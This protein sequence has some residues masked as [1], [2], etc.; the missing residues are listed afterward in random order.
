MTTTSPPPSATAERPTTPALQADGVTKRFAGVTAL[1][2]VS[3]SVQP[4][5]IHALVGENGAGKS[6]LI[7][8]LTG[9]H[10]PDEGRLLHQGVETSFGRAADAQDAGIST[11]YQEVN[12]VPLLSVA[13][14]VF[15]GR[16]PRTRLGLVDVRRME[17]EAAEITRD[18]GVDVDVTGDL[19]RLGLG[20]Q[21]MIALARAV[22]VDARVVI[23]DE[24]TSSLERREVDTLFTVARRLRD[25][26]VG[27][28]FVSHRLDELWQLCDAVTILR[29][30]RV[31][32]TGEMAPLT[33]RELISHMLGRD[34][35]D[36]A[37]HGATGFGDAAAGVGSAADADA[38]AGPEGAGGA[39]PAPEGA[40]VGSGVGTTTATPAL[41]ADPVLSVSGLD[42]R[43]ALHDVSFEV[44]QGEVLGL[45]GLLG[46]GRSETVKAAYGALA[47]T[48]GEVRVGGRP[49]RRNS[50]RASLAAGVAL[51][52]EDRKAE[53]IIPELSVRDNIVLAVMDRVSTFGVISDR[54]VDEL[55]DTFVRRLGI[56]VSSPRQLVSQL[57]GGNQ[58]K[59]LIARWLCTEPRVFLLDEPTRGIDVGAK[60]EVQ[61]L[62][63]ELASRGLGVVLISSESDELVEGS[64][65]VVVLRDGRVSARLE[66]DDVTSSRLLAA[67]VGDA[68]P[69]G[70]AS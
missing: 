56:K 22:S 61:G 55:V 49:V 5:S 29:D 24:P 65:R 37:A 58:Q 33:R 30:G 10:R 52:S 20:I 60:R 18:L 51:L 40:L 12:L 44:R 59:V 43:A 17:R 67:L 53:G 41:S 4:G 68:A 45:A 14:N 19:G 57:S 42:A 39:S 66:G 62:I 54:K 23:M 25:Q 6:T 38:D 63:D 3:F 36:V 1:S 46:S 15:L 27:I 35:D 11:V 48:G 47:T 28:V 8:V 26:G 70:G 34:I 7:K 13:R 31:V 2:D 16:E 21:Q 69:E 64:D 50:I 9:V 32:H